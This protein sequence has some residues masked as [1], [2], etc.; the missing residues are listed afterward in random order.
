MRTKKWAVGITLLLFAVFFVRDGYEKKSVSHAAD[1]EIIDSAGNA[2]TENYVLRRA[3][4]TFYV[5]G[6]ADMDTFS[7]E[8]LNPEI[9]EI[10]TATANSPIVSVTAKSF[11]SAA[12]LV[13][14]THLDS[15]TGENVTQDI[16]FSIEVRLSI[17]EDL[18]SGAAPVKITRVNPEDERLSIV[19]N[20]SQDN[21]GNFLP[22]GASGKDNRN[23]SLTL[24][25]GDATS[26]NATWSSSNE[27]VVSVQAGGIAAVGAGRALLTV[28]YR[29]GLDTYEDSIWVYVRPELHRDD[30]SG[31]LLGASEDQVTMENGDRIW[32]SARYVAQ[33]LEGI[34]NKVTWVI[35][36]R[37]GTQRTL[38]R[39]SLGNVGENPEDANLIF[40]SSAGNFRLD[41]K[42]GQ[43]VIQFFVI[44][45]Y[46]DFETAQDPARVLGC[47][48]VSISV[49]V[50]SRFR[51]EE[52]KEVTIDIGGYY[53]LA[54]AFNISL[55]S[56][57]SSE[58]FIVEEMQN[59][60]E[61]IK[62][63]PDTMTVEGL[64]EGVATFKVRCL[65]SPAIPDVYSGNTVTVR[66]NVTDTFRLNVSSATLAVGASLD[67]IG[68][69]GSGQY[70]EASSFRWETSENAE[71]YISLNSN[72]Q[73][74]TVKAVRTTPANSPVTVTLYWTN[75]EGVTRKASCTIYVTTSA[76]QLNLY[77][78]EVQMEVDQTV[79]VS[80]RLTG[81][82]N[83]LW[84][85]S[86]T[87]IVTVDPVQGNVDAFLKAG[88]K[89]GTAIVTVLNPANNAYATCRVTVSSPITDLSIEQGEYIDTV[90][91]AGFVFL[92]AKYQPADATATD[93]IWSVDDPTKA[94]VDENGVVTLL[95]EGTVR[96]DVRPAYN[97]NQVY[98]HCYI[99]VRY[100]PVTDVEVDE[101]ELYLI[102]GEVYTV[103]ARAIPNDAT[104]P[105]L[106]WTSLSPS[107]ATVD[108]GNIIAVAPGDANIMVQ[109]VD[110]P[111]KVITVHVRDRLKKI[112]FTQTEFEIKKGDTF[113]LRNAVIFDPAENVN[114]NL[115][116]ASSNNS[117][118]SVDANGN[119]TGLKAGQ[120][121]VIT[122]VAE[123]LG[124]LGAITC[125]V[126]VIDEDV[127][128]TG[129]TLKQTEA[130]MYVG[131]FL[132][133]EPIFTPVTATYQ[134]LSWS[135]TDPSIA[136]V[137]ENGMVTALA[138]GTATIT[139][140]YRNP[141]DNTVWDPV[142][143]KITVLKALV[144]VEGLALSP[145]N[146]EIYT[147]QSLAVVPVFTPADATDQGVTYQ[148]SDDS[149]ANVDEQGMVTGIASGSAVIICRSNEGGYVATCNVKVIQGVF[150]SLSPTYREIALGKTFTIKKTILPEEYADSPVTWE[151]SNEKIATVSKNG[152]VKGVKKGNCVITCTIPKYN[153][154]AV[155]EV[156]VA[157]LRTTIKLNKTNI[158]IGKGQ[159]YKL[160]ATVWTNN[161]K[162]PSVKWTTSNRRI[163]TVGQKGKVKAKKLGYATI[164][165]TTT[166]KLK[167]RAKCKVRVILRAKSVQIV[168][169]YAVCYIGG[170]KTLK[171]V[172]K[173]A[174]ATLKTVSWKSSD[175]SIATVTGGKVRGLAEGTVTITATAKDG[176][177]KKGTC[178]LKVMEEIPASSIVVAQS[179][180]TMKK[181][182]SAKLSY[183][184]L[185]NNTSD[186]ITFAS[187]NKRVAKVGADGT[188]KA[189]G[190]GECTITI[191]S[192]GGQTSTVSVNVVALNRT[193][194]TMRQYDTETLTVN[195]T[196][197]TVTWYSGN[198]RVATVEDGKVTGRSKGSTYIYAYVKG[199][200]LS[201]RVTITNIK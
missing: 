4:E 103:G 26:T 175:T 60:G 62:F 28:T 105:S 193:S 161:S 118:V 50:S 197:A 61:W 198:A 94:S 142:Y 158:R 138:E 99:N 106:T 157:S 187:D 133:M 51:H 121:A 10:N 98:A 76:T 192:S 44:G 89:P 112:S 150:L 107:V 14:I 189:V 25:F 184:V 55:S 196:N 148:S 74:A 91:A 59:D 128:A 171:A 90:L 119:I 11:G 160:K 58:Y 64:K 122:C 140:V 1:Y 79:T 8:C 84:L 75:N 115:S 82:Q 3:M 139:G 43:Y 13:R 57:R 200:K 163:A 144:P 42:A 36:K 17:N 178:I 126:R 167:V 68:I 40:D 49:N 174:N 77:P 152:K 159:T 67:L 104:N 78:D 141:I 194:L 73:Y 123:D 155:C 127:P 72:G 186:D 71:T 34:L 151:S 179:E 2:V 136:T 83:L 45:T 108:G 66:I 65:S 117:V 100:N 15:E 164:M 145:D 22:F 165:A 113:S 199:C 93:L 12:M 188:V 38:V 7:W 47:E 101:T 114:T 46:T 69:I 146:M 87:D 190:T 176:S 109:S 52:V 129:V 130:T 111:A 56:L 132:Q 102:K 183:T 30:S 95:Q 116:W 134:N 181:G 182:D 162:K 39:D 124:L 27:D 9:L 23:D 31:E 88:K 180:L 48:P 54:E 53:S 16:Y 169:N 156:K 166:D 63:D 201:C 168:P 177:G 153:A 21:I 195:G 19:M 154:K 173:P 147:G 185:P 85:S 149:I 125:W 97:P 191:M 131:D 172:V 37:S 96:V 120:T 35:A 80:T 143:C 41:A 32:V 20:Y 110:G 92:K 29:D 18:G 81:Q 5:S 33:P 70:T 86:D 137:D 170:T 135:S 6:S 24:V